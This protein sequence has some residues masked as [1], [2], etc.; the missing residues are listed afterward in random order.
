MPSVSQNDW[1]I[2]KLHALPDDGN[3]Y[4]IIDGALFVTPAPCLVHQ[5]AIGELYLQL[6]PYAKTVSMEA[7]I[8]PADIQYSP[9]TVV[10]PDLFVFRRVPGKP[11]KDWAD[12]Q[13]LVLAVE[14]LSRST[15]RRDR[16]IKRELYQAQGVPEYWIVDTDARAVERWRPDSTEPEVVRDTLV[17]QPSSER[18]PLQLVLPTF[19]SAILD[20]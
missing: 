17:W 4:E 12:V 7:M 20:G 1:T 19:F 14:V 18:G 6:A 5:G 15:R 10:Q 3:R 16:T 13:P 9:R 2:A 8:S 11:A